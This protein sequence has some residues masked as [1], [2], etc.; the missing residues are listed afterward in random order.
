MG[1]PALYDVISSTSG[2]P[3]ELPNICNLFTTSAWDT[4]LLLRQNPIKYPSFDIVTPGKDA[5]TITEYPYGT[6]GV[7]SHDTPV[8]VLDTFEKGISCSVTRPGGG[9]PISY[10]AR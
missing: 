3:A 10:A 1:F 5:L 2:C 6:S 8:S 4:R 7:S 9:L